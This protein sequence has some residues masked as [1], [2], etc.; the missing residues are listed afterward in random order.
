MLYDRLGDVKKTES[1][2]QNIETE[3]ADKSLF[4][5]ELLLAL[6]AEGSNEQKIDYKALLAPMPAVAVAQQHAPESKTSEP[7]PVISGFISSSIV[8][9][10]EPQQL[11]QHRAVTESSLPVEHSVAT[12]AV[13]HVGRSNMHASATTPPSDGRIFSHSAASL[14]SRAAAK[15]KPVPAA[16]TTKAGKEATSTAAAAAQKR[17]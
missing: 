8:E 11:Q 9:N 15:R 6:L 14:G 4:V 16:N 13:S 10:R 12:A 5:Q 17:H 1:E 3:R 7:L 2:Q